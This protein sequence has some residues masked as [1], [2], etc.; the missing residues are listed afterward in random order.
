MGVSNL[1]SGN[2]VLRLLIK[3]L[4][5]G[6]SFQYNKKEQSA[7]GSLASQSFARS[8]KDVISNP[9]HGSPESSF[10]SAMSSAH[11]CASTY[12]DIALAGPHAVH[13]VSDAAGTSPPGPTVLHD[14]DGFKTVIYKK[15]TPPVILLLVTLLQRMLNVIGSCSLGFI[16]L[17][18][19]L[20]L[21]DT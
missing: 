2:A 7:S 20:S 13:V 17:Q 8:C 16:T 10:P 3:N 14:P 18:P 4:P 1:K 12:Q 9:P 6:P 15:T 21:Q 5:S 11:A 19:C